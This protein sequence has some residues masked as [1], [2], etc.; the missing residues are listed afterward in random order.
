[1]R[2]IYAR[3]MNWLYKIYLRSKGLKIGQ[4]TWPEL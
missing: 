1:M 3:V 2:Y 4:G